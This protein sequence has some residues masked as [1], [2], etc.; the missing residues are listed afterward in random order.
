VGEDAKGIFYVKAHSPVDLTLSLD[1]L[2]V[3]KE[4][5]D[6][7]GS[8]L[9]NN[10]IILSNVD[11]NITPT[12]KVL[13]ITDGNYSLSGWLA[14]QRAY[15]LN[16]NN[17]PIKKDEIHTYAI[18]NWKDYADGKASIN[19]TIQKDGKTY[20]RIVGASEITKTNYD[21]ITK[22]QPKP[23]HNGNQTADNTIIYAGS[24][25][26]A[27]GLGIGL[28]AYA[29]SRRR[30]QQPLIQKPQQPQVHTPEAPQTPPS[31]DL[32]ASDYAARQPTQDLYA[33]DYSARE[34]QQY[35]QESWQP[36]QEPEIPA[37]KA[38]PVRKSDDLDDILNQLK[39]N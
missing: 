18:L 13:G 6:I 29:L 16:F 4:Y 31:Q 35:Q 8:G 33:S 2:I 20:S 25:A 27:T 10:S 15:E 24:A 21:E 28:G 5:A 1:D 17:I 26:G 38:K 30:K 3:D 11:E 39:D 7:P 36:A 22:E 23:P 19:W 32:Y 9:E 12:L 37:V 34:Q 14:T